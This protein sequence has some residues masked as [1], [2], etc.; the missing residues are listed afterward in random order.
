LEDDEEQLRYQSNLARTKADTVLSTSFLA[1]KL[2][3]ELFVR[4]V[5]SAKQILTTAKLVLA[6][7]ELVNH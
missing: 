1:Q 3:K 7:A 6:G 4:A 2:L 5:S